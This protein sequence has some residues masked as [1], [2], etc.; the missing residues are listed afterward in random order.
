V[1]HELLRTRI[2]GR[3]VQLAAPTVIKD[4]RA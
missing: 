1:E 2:G 4:V 3:G